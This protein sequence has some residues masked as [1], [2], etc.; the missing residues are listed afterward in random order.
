MPYEIL[1][2]EC[3]VLLQISNLVLCGGAVQI[4]TMQSR[5]NKTIL[6]PKSMVPKS[7]VFML[8]PYVSQS[9]PLA[10]TNFVDSVDYAE[11]SSNSGGLAFQ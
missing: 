4:S 2:T 8:R 10:K 9:Q 5:L 1:R 3:A 7:M 11:D 6:V